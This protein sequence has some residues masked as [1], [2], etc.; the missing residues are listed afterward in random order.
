MGVYYT[1]S[2]VPPK[3]EFLCQQI[4]NSMTLMLYGLHCYHY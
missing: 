3:W 4:V 2:M 1:D